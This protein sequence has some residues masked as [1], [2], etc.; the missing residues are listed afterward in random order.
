MMSGMRWWQ[1]RIL[2]V[3]NTDDRRKWFLSTGGH[4]A[5]FREGGHEIFR[6]FVYGHSSCGRRF[7]DGGGVEMRV[8]LLGIFRQMAV[9][10]KARIMYSN[11]TLRRR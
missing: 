1:L 7:S 4:V 11:E 2:S 9:Y 3:R 8:K 5:F 10:L 6:T